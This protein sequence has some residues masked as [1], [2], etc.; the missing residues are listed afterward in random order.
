MS[1][2]EVVNRQAQDEGLWF[3]AE[4]APEAYLQQALR[5][6][7]AAVESEESRELVAEAVVAEREAI[8]QLVEDADIETYRGYVREDNARATLRNAARA[9]RA[10]GGQ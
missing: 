3:R 6:L 8:A 2:R 1:A 7:H 5:E 4:T 9:I 10:R